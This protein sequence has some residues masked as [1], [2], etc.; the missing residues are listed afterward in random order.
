MQSPHRVTSLTCYACQGRSLRSRLRSM[1]IQSSCSFEKWFVPH[2]VLTATLA[3]ELPP[4]SMAFLWWFS[5]RLSALLSSPCVRAVAGVLCDL[6]TFIGDAMALLRWCSR[7]HGAQV[8]VLD[9]YL[10]CHGNA[11]LGDSSLTLGR[12]WQ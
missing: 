3:L 10:E 6:N 8:G 4:S 5:S 9:C 12:D 1:S 7:F 2:A 11:A